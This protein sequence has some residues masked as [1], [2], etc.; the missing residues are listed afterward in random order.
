M[1]LFSVVSSLLAV[2]C[3]NTLPLSL[4]CKECGVWVQIK[5]DR[6]Y[7]AGTQVTDTKAANWTLLFRDFTE[8]IST[9]AYFEC[10]QALCLYKIIKALYKT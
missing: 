6:S 9:P 4:P 2:S 1:F 10:E 8:L 7:R 3:Q 5:Y